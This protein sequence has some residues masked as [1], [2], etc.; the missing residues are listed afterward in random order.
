MAW[1]QWKQSLPCAWAEAGFYDIGVDLQWYGTTVVQWH[2]S[3]WWIAVMEV[4]V[5]TS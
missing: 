4:A 1:F 5:A 2:H 3:N